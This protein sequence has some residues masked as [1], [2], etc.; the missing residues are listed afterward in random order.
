MAHELEI[1]DGRASMAYAGSVPWH[2]L[3]QQVDPDVSP[4]EMMKAAN[5]DWTVEKHPL[6]AH[7]TDPKDGKVKSYPSGRYALVRSTDNSILTVCGQQWTATQNEEAFEFFKHFCDAGNAKMETA[8]SLFN[9]QIVWAM[10]KLTAKFTTGDGGDLTQGYLLFSLPHRLGSSIQ[11]RT[12]SVR[13]VCNNTLTFSLNSST[14]SEYRQSH[15]RAFD[16]DAAKNV[17]QLANDTIVEQG[18]FAEKLL[19]ISFNEKDAIRFFNGLISD[20]ALI[21]VKEEALL[22]YINTARGENSRLGQLMESYHKAPGATPGSA[23]GV[24]N[25]V[26]HYVDHKE[27]RDNNARLNNAWYGNGDRM[28]RKAVLTLND[29]VS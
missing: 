8:G 15:M 3:G 9:G 14:E 17:V 19:K 27:A 24:L 21:D 23:W 1:V 28:K 11:V 25:A 5:L 18:K 2:G 6:Y 16:F 10:A 29:L 13:V 20:E 26:T 7:L 12:T 22:E 4:A